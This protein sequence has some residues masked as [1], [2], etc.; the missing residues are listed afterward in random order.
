[1]S[2]ADEAVVRVV[3]PDWVHR[4]SKVIE[5][6][7]KFGEL[8]RQ[9]NEA[10]N[11]VSRE[12][13][14]DLWHRHYADS[15]QLLTLMDRPPGHIVDLGSGGGFPAVPLALALPRTR[16]TLIDSNGRK[17]AFLRTVA[18][19]L[20]LDIEV[21]TARVEVLDLSTFPEAE[22]ITARA[23][24][25][26][27][28]LFGYCHPMWREGTR[29]LF[30]KGREYRAETAEALRNWRFDLLE[31]DNLIERGGVILDIRNLAPRNETD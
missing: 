29:G 17:G 28:R 26:L 21:L 15:L 2:G 10:Q 3:L 18:R 8:L 31:H 1:M 19:E 16:F 20:D 4:P 27:D 9:W 22:I 14:P 5:G 24:A 23:F 12:T 13:L 30:H 7:E 25:P 6:L 11:L